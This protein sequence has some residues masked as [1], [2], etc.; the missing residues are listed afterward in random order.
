MHRERERVHVAWWGVGVGW[1]PGRPHREASTETKICKV[2]GGP[3]AEDGSL[4]VGVEDFPQE[5]HKRGKGSEAGSLVDGASARGSD[6][7]ENTSRLVLLVGHGTG[8][9]SVTVG[10]E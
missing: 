8:W 10:E 4:A 6:E 9:D 1:Q 3:Q 7:R 2:G 5:E